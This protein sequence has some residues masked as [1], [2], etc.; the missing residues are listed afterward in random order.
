M[1]WLTKI[2][3]NTGLTPIDVYVMKQSA[4]ADS[5]DA[6][7]KAKLK[8]QQKAKAAFPDD[9]VRQRQNY[10]EWNQANFRKVRPSPVSN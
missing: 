4:W 7:D 3:D 2:D 6:W 8:A 10:D 9:I 1:A 5:Q